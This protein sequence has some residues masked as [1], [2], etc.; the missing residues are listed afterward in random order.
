MKIAI[1]ALEGRRG[2]DEAALTIRITN[3]EMVEERELVVA[4]RMLF[5]VGNIAGGALPY[6]LSCE[7]F[8][9]LEYDAKLWEAVKKAYDLLAY[10]DN[11]KKRLAEKLR[12]RGFD[13]EIAEEAAEYAEKLGI[14][15][16]KRQLAHI[17][18]QLTAKCYGR[19]RIKQELMKKGISR[20]I[21]DDELDELLEEVDFDELLMK[22]LRKKVD[23]SLIGPGPEGRKYREKVISAMFRYGYSPDTVRRALRELAEEG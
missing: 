19:S 14:V 13:R 4:S 6:E 1:I 17:V 22:L 18:S 9:V 15:D 20:E 21:I 16:E 7:Q 8:D 11:S 12:Q 3:G 10:G 5:E 23:V 2:G